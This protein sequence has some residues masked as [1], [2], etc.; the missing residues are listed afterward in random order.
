MKSSEYVNNERRDYSLYVLQSRA[1][2]HAA[3]GLKAAARRVLWT[4][5]N[6]QKYK[7]A[8]LAG[9]TMPIHPHQAPE[10]AV[11]TLAAP[12]GNNI[13][14]LDG[15]GAFGTL[16]APTAYGAARYTSVKVSE[17]TKDVVFRD[18][19][20]IPLTEN[21]DGTLE[22]P[23]HFLPLVP[24]VLLN[25]QDGIAVGF[26][27][28]ILPRALDSIIKS[29]LD[30]LTSGTFTEELPTMV[31]LN[32]RAF[33]WAETGTGGYK[34]LFQGEVEQINATTARITNL[35]YG[36]P[37]EKYITKLDK[38]EENGTIQEYVDNSRDSYNIEVRFKKGTLSSLKEHQSLTELLELN[39]WVS[40]NMNVIDF[41]GER[42]W[43]TNY[44]EVIEKF[45]EWRLGWYVKRYER[46]AGLL[47]ID[48]QK[49]KDVLRAIA[50]NVGGAAKKIGSRSELK[51]FLTEIEIVYV[52][53]I[54]DLPV[55]RFTEDEKRKVEEKLKEAEALMKEYKALLKS[56][57]KRRDVYV[58][59]LTE[60]LEK[61]KRGGYGK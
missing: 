1:I 26:A 5:K 46:L 33:D 39:N 14:L 32:Q 43:S 28:S 8:T 23:K 25:P 29:Q 22:E 34:Y 44:E 60:I 6:G 53:Y 18:I 12:Y 58:N 42:V 17:F 55:Y 56:P 21:Y 27:S 36:V 51:E 30:Y 19:E 15:D 54:A 2:P 48:I 40:E 7:S 4:A 11:N 13:P 61:Y 31:P 49:Y 10:G 20:V 45:T 59:E 41:D 57:K 9:A 37:H 38:L 3:D 47:E 50:R 35:P 16:L 24:I 52:D